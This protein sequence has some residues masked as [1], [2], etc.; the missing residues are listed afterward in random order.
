MTKRRTVVIGDRLAHHRVTMKAAL[1]AEHGLRVTTLAGLASR[2]ARPL[3][4]IADDVVVR[5]ALANLPVGEL[6]SLASVAELPGFARAAAKS[7]RSAW[8]A[9]I[10]IQAMGGS[11]GGRWSEMAALELTVLERL[12]AGVFT[13]PRVVELARANVDLAERITGYITL[14]GL[15]EVH[16][17]FRPLLADLAKR[18]NVGWRGR[19]ES[20]ASPLPAGVEYLAP[21][22]SAAPVALDLCAD[23]L[24]EVVEAFRWARRLL[25]SGEAKPGEIAIAAAS[26]EPYQDA[27][28]ALADEANLPLHFAHGLPARA[29][30]DSQTA[31]ALAD[32]LVRGIDRPRVKRLVTLCRGRG[33][34]MPQLAEL[35][36]NWSRVLPEDAPLTTP[37]RWERSLAAKDD[38]LDP[39]RELL[40]ELGRDLAKGTEAAAE[41]GER[42]LRGRA[43]QLWRRALDEGPASA[44]DVS[45]SLLSV[46]DGVEPA[47]AIVWASASSLAGSPRPFVRLL[48]RLHAPGLA[49]A[50]MIRCCRGTAWGTRSYTNTPSRSATGA[51]STRSSPA[52]PVRWRFRARSGTPKAGGWRRVPCCNGSN[53]AKLGISF[54][55]AS[56]GTPSARRTDGWPGPANS[57]PILSLA[58]PSLPGAT[59]SRSA[60]PASMAGCGQ[61]T[62]PPF[63]PTI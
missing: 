1:E 61:I 41:I 20:P 35:P 7:L 54:P 53:P 14:D 3:V 59:G 26:P 39:A 37:E 60:L 21:G 29:T 28:V 42:W 11:H 44:V 58:T 50:A 30:R 18:V 24:H 2:L 23:P 56:L 40:R 5:R 9:G 55:G 16:P 32:V 48:G 45:L 47:A 43:R 25:A 52:R 34:G 27:F 33:A 15:D 17:V 62:P 46:D 4:Q 36:S 51:P 31:A 10:D 38:E 8:N 63:A 6:G 22:T 12:P 13:T 57:P 49:A 19:L